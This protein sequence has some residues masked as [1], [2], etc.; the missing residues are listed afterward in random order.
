MDVTNQERDALVERLMRASAGMFEIYTT[1]LG[2][3]LGLYRA[4]AEAGPC[5]SAELAAHTGTN[6]RYVREWLEQQAVIGIL[7]VDDAGA[8]A[9]NRRYQ[10]PAGHAEVLVERDSLNYLAPLAQLMVGTVHPLSAILEAFRTGAGVPFGVYGADMCE[11][12]GALNRAA[13]LQSLG[14]EWLPAIPDV[15][16]RLQVDPPARVADIGSGAGWGSIGLARTYPKVQVDGF[17]L[18]APSVAL[19][20]DNARAMGVADRVHFAVRDAAAVAPTQSYDLVLAFE[21][22]HDMADPVGALRGM[23]HL[24]GDGGAV[25]VMDERVGE[26]FAARNEDTEWF[27]YGFSV[28]RC[29]PAGL[30]DQPSTG[31]GTVMRP[32][33]FRRYALE[34]GY[35]DVVILPIENFFYTFYRLVH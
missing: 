16:A 26:S 10:L 28:L 3:R 2:D 14:H 30:A 33:T 4:L 35:R 24:A 12:Q 1:Y 34:A 21:C 31:T 13:F 15:H 29:L 5:T 23:R 25:I 32:D 18:D 27:M 19:A 7:Q 20:K 9:S 6:E 8:A 17:D 11:G 22:V